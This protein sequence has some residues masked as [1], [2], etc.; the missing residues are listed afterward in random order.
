MVIE[1]CVKCESLIWDHLTYSPLNRCLRITCVNI[2]AVIVILLSFM[3]MI[4]FSDWEVSLKSGA[5]L[6]T[7][8]PNKPIDAEIAYYDWVKPPRQR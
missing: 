6:E 8:C 7:K 5:G 2:L 4:Y 3:A 1:E